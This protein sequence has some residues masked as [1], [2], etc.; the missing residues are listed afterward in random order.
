MS[1]Y[2]ECVTQM[3]RSGGKLDQME[4]NIV[5]SS[6]ANNNSQS[7]KVHYFFCL[8]NCDHISSKTLVGRPRVDKCGTAAHRPFQ[9]I[10]TGCFSAPTWCVA[11]VL[12]LAIAK[13]TVPSELLDI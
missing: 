2:G 10:P 8:T 6:G 11:A 7:N 3:A 5:V 13:G 4:A 12:P 1:Y 9:Q